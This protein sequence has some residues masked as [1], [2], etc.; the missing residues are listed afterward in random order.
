M[1]R[2]A[3]PGQS[4]TTTPANVPLPRASCRRVCTPWNRPSVADARRGR[5]CPG[6]RPGPRRA[7]S[8]RTADRRGVPAPRALRARSRGLVADQDRQRA[9]S[10]SGLG[11]RARARLPQQRVQRL[12]RV[13]VGLRVGD[14]RDLVRDRRPA[15]RRSRAGTGGGATP[16][17]SRA[18]PARLRGGPSAAV[19][20]GAG[21][22]PRPPPGARAQG[23]P[24]RSTA[25]ARPSAPFPRPSCTPPLPRLSTRP[26]PVPRSRPAVTYEP[27]IR[28]REGVNESGRC[29]G[30]AQ[31]GGAVRE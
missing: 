24:G 4:R 30:F 15:R 20:P 14:Q 1:P 7:G 25:N 11:D 16:A 29:A 10:G 18:S 2:T 5:R 6:R 17:G 28:A 26:R 19:P 27:T 9:R 12:H 22:A 31:P 8:R 21:G 23:R 13:R 3:V